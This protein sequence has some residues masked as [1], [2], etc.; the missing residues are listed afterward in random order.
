[1]GNKREIVRLD[2]FALNDRE[3]GGILRE[4][5][6]EQQNASL[7]EQKEL[8]Y[9]CEIDRFGRF[10]INAFYRRG[11][12]GLVVRSI[13]ADIPSF[14][15][16]GLPNILTAFTKLKAG[17]VLVTGTTGSGKST[18]LASL[19]DIINKERACHIVT[20]ED[21]IEF[22][23]RSDKAIISQREVGRDTKSYNEALKRVLREDPDVILVGEIRDADT[24]KVVM[25]MAETGHLVFST[26]HTM[27]V[28]QTINR[29]ANFF[30]VN[31]QNKVRSQ[32]SAVLQGIASQMLLQRT[33]GKG[34]VCA[35]EIVKVNQAIRNL[36]R[37]N[38]AHQI[39]SIMDVSKKEGMICMDDA[40]SALYQKGLIEI[41]D[42]I[43]HSTKGK[44]VTGRTP[45]NVPKGA[46]GRA[47]G[48][49]PVTQ[50]NMLLY[51][52][53]FSLE[54]LSYFDAS[55]LLWDTPDGLLFRDD[56][57]I[58]SEFNFMVD[59][60]ILN[61]KKAAFSLKSS[62]SLSYKIEDTKV[63]RDR[64]YFK[65]RVISDFK[66]EFEIPKTPL[67]LVKDGDWHIIMLPIPKFYAGKPVKYY[68]LL[69]DS[70]IREIVLR[71][72]NFS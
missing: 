22:V 62:F 44:G 63:R 47:V 50:T 39:Y 31:E 20:V 5:A 41:T 6:T 64:Y 48:G 45:G 35:C 7:I 34:V 2:N 18:T 53:D 8:D 72:I 12:L 66:D 69:F 51:S 21:P 46:A 71:N 49:D 10:R 26:L 33:D 32:L 4:T 37:E 61:G 19:I 36:I 56:G 68:T 9:S 29:I 24:M 11:R 54:N 17:L 40:L 57:R 60:T 67:E 23:Y 14:S 28:F 65:L 43:M 59:Y 58:K 27:N 25:E 3:I 13:P 38:K 55:G 15:S 30:S 52:A 42:T 70:N 16:L 1:M